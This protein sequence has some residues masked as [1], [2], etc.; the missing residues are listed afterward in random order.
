MNSKDL[1]IGTNYIYHN[2]ETYHSVVFL[3][4]YKHRKLQT[5]IFHFLQNNNNSPFNFSLY[6]SEDE[7]DRVQMATH[8]WKL[9]YEG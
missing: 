4:K 7:L 1:V 9:L 5:E 2:E 6:L 3:S 8:L